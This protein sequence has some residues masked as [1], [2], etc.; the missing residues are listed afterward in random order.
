[1][2]F[3]SKVTSYNDS[4]LPLAIKALKIISSHSIGTLNL[5]KKME[6]GSNDFIDSI[7]L[8]YALKM[9]RLNEKGEIENVVRSE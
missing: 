5:F 4:I 7:C 3:P 6:I 1:M 2:K 9:I 8:L